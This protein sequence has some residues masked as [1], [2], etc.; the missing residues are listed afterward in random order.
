MPLTLTVPTPD[1]VEDL[2]VETRVKPLKEW[3]ENLPLAN[4]AEAA[5]NLSEELGAL[6]RQKLALDTRLKLLEL[7][8]S[9]IQ[10]LMP[11]M[12]A[13][14]VAARLPLPEKNREMAMLAR[15]LQMDLANGYKIILLDYQNA[16]ITLGKGKA[17][18]TAAQRA[19]SGLSQIL[20][21]CYQTYAPQPAGIWS[22]IHQIFRFAI[23]QDI[24][25]KPVD[26]AGTES[27][28]SLVYK[29]ALLL[30]LANPYHLNPGEVD[31]ILGYL[32][33]FGNLALLQPFA[34]SGSP[35]GLFL[36]ATQGDN[37]PKL[38][39]DNLGEVDNR[40]DILL[41]ALELAHALKHH[42][43]QLEAGET[44]KTLHLPDTAKQVGYQD[45]LKR[46]LKQWS[47]APKRLFQRNENI[48][49]TELCIGIPALHHFLG[50]S[51]AGDQTDL[52]FVKPAKDPRF[53]SGKWLIINE[54]AGG[55]ALRGAFEIL[56]QIRPG[57]I[58]GL[59]SDGEHQ[60]NIG[61]V[62]WVK[63]DKADHLEI[64]AQRLAPKAEPVM[65][66][67]S[68]AG[69]ADTFQA[70]LLLPE[71]LLLKQPETMITPRGN[72]SPQR[73]LVVESSG[74]T[75]QF[76]VRADK[77]TEQTAGFERFQFKRD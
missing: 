63:S 64:G 55:L 48:S 72:F 53:I 18:M 46:L 27:S 11:D 31:C 77:L 42:I 45:L 13:Q 52:S 68:I 74:G 20:A 57:D 25:N 49:S 38:M 40:N 32:R 2:T 14:Y 54:S 21:I 10:R 7:Y 60:W 34:P 62:R 59:K 75:R 73:E 70:A 56:P 16:R 19:I 43:S 69:P 15:Q 29:Q 37:P 5:R 30:A 9:T 12:E 39:P 58:I 44:P 3:L 8:R 24:A 65:V 66:K 67:P 4:P 71:I 28:L 1:P 22:E 33:V 41:N 50:G 23:E 76:L 26:D 6:N 17:A 47:V 36:V 35:V 61:V 51:E